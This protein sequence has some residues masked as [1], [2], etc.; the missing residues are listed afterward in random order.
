MTKD[1][2]DAAADPVADH[3]ASE[4][5]FYADPESASRSAIGAIKNHELR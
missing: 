5:F 2:P 3:R 4:R 1:F